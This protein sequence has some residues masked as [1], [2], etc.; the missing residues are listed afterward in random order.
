[1]MAPAGCTTPAAGVT[2]TKP[3]SM[4]EANPKAVG[5]PA[6]NASIN[7]HANAP[8]AAAAC[9][10]VNACAVANPL[11]TELPALNPNQP[12]QSRPAPM[13]TITMLLGRMDAFG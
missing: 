5:F 3:A 12:T 1:A 8:A 6:W 10:A 2:A 9:V 4:P 11:D 13:S 7:I